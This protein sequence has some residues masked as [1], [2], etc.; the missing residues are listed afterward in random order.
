[1]ILLDHALSAT[2][3]EKQLAVIWGCQSSGANA[4]ADI[5]ASAGRANR[6]PEENSLLSPKQQGLRWAGM[7]HVRK[8]LSQIP[9]HR[10]VLTPLADSHLAHRHIEALTGMR[11]LWWVRPV[12]HSISHDLKRHPNTA[13]LGNVQPILDNCKR[14]WRNQGISSGTRTLFHQLYDRTLPQADL[15]A[16][17]WYARNR[18]Y[19]EQDLHREPQVQCLFEPQVFANPAGVAEQMRAHLRWPTAPALSHLRPPVITQGIKHPLIRHLCQHLYQQL[20]VAQARRQR[21]KI[22]D[23][24]KHDVTRE[25]AKVSLFLLRSARSKKEGGERHET[26]PITNAPARERRCSAIQTSF[27]SPKVDLYV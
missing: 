11:G 2:L 8:A 5:L 6:L 22:N 19:F 23:H 10:V 14:D 13:G 3:A 27:H 25:A 24:P 16:L 15:G 12:F 26:S 9:N 18:L 7:Q 20:V 1:M 21:G 17:F 4:I